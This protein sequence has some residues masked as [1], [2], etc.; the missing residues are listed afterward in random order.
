MM[1]F[2]FVRDFDKFGYYIC[3]VMFFKLWEEMYV[4]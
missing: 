3:N 4:N 1:G 2:G